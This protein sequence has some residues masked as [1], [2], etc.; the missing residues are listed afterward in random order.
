MYQQQ[1]QQYEQQQRQYE[2]QQNG[3]YNNNYWAGSYYNSC[4]WYDF[5][6]KYNAKK[7]QAMYQNQNGQQQGG[8][9]QGDNNI[10]RAVI[11]GWYYLFGGQIEMEDDR[12]RQEMGM[13]SES[14]EGGMKFVY[15]CSI[16]LFTALTIFGLYSMYTGKERMGLIFALVTF[17]IFTLMNLLTT[18]QGT[19]ETDNR[20]FE[21][22]IY[23][24]F[25][26]WAVLTAYTDF[27]MICH[28]FFFALLLGV[29]KVLDMR[30]KRDVE[31]E[32]LDSYDHYQEDMKIEQNSSPDR[33]EDGY[34]HAEIN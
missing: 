21:D 28:C 29:L 33:I 6:C 7:Y 19:I 11:P 4:S 2:Q 3:N 32:E 13:T 9:G 30:A 16:I 25:G 15:A 27:W 8:G 5:K 23:G 10:V 31:K 17:G 26:Q 34:V 20:F 14:E 18:V 1:Q 12:Q 22:S 24:W